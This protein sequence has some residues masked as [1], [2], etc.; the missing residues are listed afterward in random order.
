MTNS[1]RDRMRTLIL[2]VLR[3]QATCVHIPTV[4]IMQPARCFECVADDLMELFPN[5]DVER[6][7]WPHTHTR[8]VLRTVA[9]PKEVA[10][11]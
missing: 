3:A 8:L 2:G 4:T 5:V 7:I 1:V 10:G 11:G 6:W 9:E